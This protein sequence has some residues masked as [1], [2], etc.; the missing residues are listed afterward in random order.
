M[1]GKVLWHHFQRLLKWTITIWGNA[2][3]SAECGLV[4]HMRWC[5]SAWSL[6]HSSSQCHFCLAQFAVAAKFRSN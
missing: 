2:L 6:E 5:V 3:S 4:I 1:L